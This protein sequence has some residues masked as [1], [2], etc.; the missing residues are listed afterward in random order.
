M[1]KIDAEC[2]FQEFDL[3]VAASGNNQLVLGDNIGQI[4]L[5]NRSWHVV[6][7]RGYELRVTLAEQLRNSPLLITIGVGLVFEIAYFH[8]CCLV[9]LFC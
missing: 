1:L 2:R 3:V 8:C 6:S 5:I 4:H 9:H 7:F